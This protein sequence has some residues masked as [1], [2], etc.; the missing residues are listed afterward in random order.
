M[1]KMV[2]AAL[3]M[4]A[5]GSGACAE[6]QAVPTGRLP[7]SVT[8]RAY[9]L[10][11]KTD[12]AQARF[13]GHTEIDV[14]LAEPARTIF[15]HGLDLRVSR[16]RVFAGRA[17]SLA[18]YTQVDDTGVVRLDLPHVL[19]AGEA[20]LSFDY[21]AEFGS[22]GAGLYR[23]K[24]GKDWYA[25]TQFEA[26]D[27]RRMFP[28]FDE[29]GF[30]TPF[31]LTV[32]A[33]SAT[34]VYANAPEVR[35]TRAGA[36]T[37]HHFAPTKPLPTYLVAIGVGPFDVV[38][39]SVAPN[40]V[41]QAPLRLRV[42]ATRGQAPRM[43]FAAAEAPKLLAAL[44]AYLGVTYPYE[45]L[46]FLASPIE[47]GA[48]EN[49]GL[50]IFQD[51]LIL[52]DPGA[53]LSQLRGF[54]EVS[55][56]EIAH[57]WFGDL[58]TPT[59]WTDIW[60]NE[61][62]AEW[63]GKKIGDQ[64][65]PDLG[66]GV[67]ELDDA[68]GAMDVDALGH[69]RP[70]HQPIAENRQIMSAFDDITY[71]K[72]AHVLSMFESYLGP[73]N[74]RKGVHRHLDHYRYGNATADDFFRSIAEASAD[75]KVVSAMRTFTDQTGVPVVTVGESAEGMKLSQARY[76]P[77]GVEA[78]AGQTW[79]IPMC[80]ARAASRS[81]LLLESASTVVPR[82][83]GDAPLLP[84]ADGA[85]YYRYSLDAAGWDRLIAVGATLPSRDAL[86]L[87]DSLRADFWAGSGS[88]ERVIA[89]ARALSGHPERLV[90]IALGYSL[91]ELA[92]SALTKEQQ[93]AY[94]SLMRSIYGQRLA[95]LGLEPRRGAYE[96]EPV[97]RQAMRQSLVPLVALEG[98]DPEVRAKLT[99]AA[100][101]MLAGDDRALDPAFRGTA[102]A[103][104]VQ[105]RGVAFM[106]SLRDALAR[107]SDPLFRRHAV[108]ALASA[109]TP[110]LADAAFGL[111]KSAGL[112]SLESLGI[113][114]G[115]S[116]QPG[117]RQPVVDYVERNFEQVLGQIPGGFRQQVI[118]IFDGYCAQGDVARIDAF[119]EP[120]L[121]LIG[122]GGLE[123]AQTKERVALCV[124]LRNAKANEIAAV[125][126]K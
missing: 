74:F 107:S 33:P 41:R 16:A 10:T 102:L 99:S 27:A 89:G 2:V 113:V 9:R 42:I 108:G 70:I 46:D 12:P 32:T 100:V 14:V 63:L 52:L 36:Q 3:A 111:A 69:G 68:F 106:A 61:S 87:A 92:A 78:P 7:Q 30:K 6:A 93:P 5:W 88:F 66:I 81:C 23:A 120:R 124:A 105:D 49:A 83:A 119:I 116:R 77:L 80:L 24:V 4:L 59:W 60:L 84:N 45:K 48:M 53:P 71:R 79:M 28:G 123:I 115:M 76:R 62:F 55:A 17:A 65:R 44:E 109:D 90:A 39:S 22:A 126:G 72:G 13:S 18:R 35:A 103:V 15:L 47:G 26:I 98:R 86:A 25:W 118:H 20:T 1:M 19:P 97:A 50:I 75:A 125:L 114:F 51:A 40:A 110:E 91:Q 37:V 101:S 54:A 64:W 43:R 38:E 94:Q 96:A 67:S 31:T 57:Q 11:L 122:G 73:E 8:P 21:T 117:A 85:G 58:V 112:Q 95:A 121:K 82:I 56:H 104:A 34:K 29:P